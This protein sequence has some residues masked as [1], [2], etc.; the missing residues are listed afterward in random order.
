MLEIVDFSVL[1]N[2]HNIWFQTLMMLMTVTLSTLKCWQQAKRCE[3]CPV[4]INSLQ[5]QNP[6]EL[7][8]ILSPFYR[9]RNSSLNPLFE[10]TQLVLE[11]TEFSF[12]SFWLQN[13]FPELLVYAEIRGLPLGP[14]RS[15]PWDRIWRPSSLM[16][17]CLGR[18][19]LGHKAAIY[20]VL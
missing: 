2:E 14:H 15:R 10:T 19:S 4:C 13:P 20:L 18:E 8:P 5:P 9:W 12:R 3:K 17:T 7:A 16:H 11:E 1:Q 6:C